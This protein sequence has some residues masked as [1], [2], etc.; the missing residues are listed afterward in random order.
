MCV[1]V[2]VGKSFSTK[3]LSIVP[4]ERNSTT[5]IEKRREY[6]AWAAN[7]DERDMIFIDEFGCN[8]HTVRK[9]GRARIGKR[10]ETN[11]K[12]GKGANVSIIAAISPT[13]GLIHHRASLETT[14]GNVRVGES[15]RG[16][17][18]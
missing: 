9:R 6:C 17:K 16:G 4:V 18:K 8:L 7:I 13:Y 1:H 3:C 12:G 2:C 11:V 5:N 14:D 15:E 10:A